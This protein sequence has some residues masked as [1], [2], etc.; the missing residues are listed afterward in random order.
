MKPAEELLP[1]LDAQ[2][3]TLQ[4]K[5]E[6]MEKMAECVRQGDM[7]GLGG[8]VE[9]EATLARRESQLEQQTQ[10]MRARLA[11][12]THSNAEQLTLGRLVEM[13]EGPLAIQLSD[14]RERLVLLVERLREK[15]TLTAM[16]VAQV[17]ELNQRMLGALSG[18]SGSGSTYSPEGDVERHAALSTFRRSV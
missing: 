6:L 12:L 10:Q 9:D 4:A 1:I 18:C 15:A 17:L 14:R 11:R 16:M 5:L 7:E 8:L 3:E 13:V 2:I